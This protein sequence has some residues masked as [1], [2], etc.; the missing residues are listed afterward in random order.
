MPAKNEHVHKYKK[1]NIGGY[2]KP[3]V[4]VYK[5]VLPD[6]THYTRPQ[7]IVGKKCV[8]CRCE[9]VFIIKIEHTWRLVNLHCDDCTESKNGG[10]S[11]KEVVEERL[12]KFLDI[13]KIGK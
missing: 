4:Y 2:K 1:V 3:K 8:C 5:C 11:K 6:C 10:K 13:L 12:D 7:F 9:R